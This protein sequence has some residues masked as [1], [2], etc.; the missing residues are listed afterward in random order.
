MRFTTNGLIFLTAAFPFLVP[1]VPTTDT[2]P[3]FSLFAVTFATLAAFQCLSR[4]VLLQ[5]SHFI[6]AGA[7]LVSGVIWLGLS[8]TANEFAT[9]NINRIV[10]FGMFL[11]AIA[12]GLLNRHIFTTDRV[13][14]ALKFYL[15]FTFIFF[16]TRGK[17]ESLLIKSRSEEALSGILQSGRG[18]STLSPEPSLFAFQIF[19]LF[20]VAR[21]TVWNDLSQRG[22]HLVQLMTIGL[23]LASFAGY[24]ILYAAAVI[25]LSGWRYMLPAAVLGGAGLFLLIAVYDVDSLRFIQLFASLASSF[26]S[27]EFEVR[28]V[29]TL[30]RLNSFVDYLQ[31]FQ[32]NPFFGDAF[33][34]YGGGGLVS[35]PAALGLYGLTLLLV[36]VAAIFVSRTDWK[37]KLVLLFWFALQSISGPLG[38]PLLGLLIGI[39]IARSWL[40]TFVSAINAVWSRPRVAPAATDSFA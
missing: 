32:S 37:M 9:E 13:V 36:F 39:V 17:I 5:K 29:S 33:G 15:F 20:L 19:S 38:L 4:D 16:A 31:I 14:R 34:Y 2:Q 30:T 40:S 8:L 11:I 10:S 7:I 21:L 22:R 35:L 1:L 12:A 3:T 26:A 28:D 27:G 25:F 18:A 23:L 24:G 6:L